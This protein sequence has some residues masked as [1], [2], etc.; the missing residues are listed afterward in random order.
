MAKLLLF[1]AAVFVLL[2]LLRGALGRRGGA[3]GAPPPTNTPQPIIACAYCGLHLPRDEA[4]P[5][6]GGVFCGEPHR[7]AFE[8]ERAPSP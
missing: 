5:G 4:L 1:L 8:K 2:W 6:R 7:A 3:R